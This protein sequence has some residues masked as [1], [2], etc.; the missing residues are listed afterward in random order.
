MLVY[1]YF[2]LSDVWV[3]DINGAFTTKRK[4]TL[5]REI[6]GNQ[7]SGENGALE[8]KERFISTAYTILIFVPFFMSLADVSH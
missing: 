1:V 2:T 4:E 8:G 7:H 5:T 6:S 3:T